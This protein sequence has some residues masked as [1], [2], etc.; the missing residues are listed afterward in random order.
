MLYTIDFRNLQLTMTLMPAV[1][2]GH[3]APLFTVHWYNPASPRLIPIIGYSSP[4]TSGLPVLVQVTFNGGV[5][6]AEH[7]RVTLL[8]STTV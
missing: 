2:A 8:P 6:E 1:F 4:E 7:A 5:P 3:S